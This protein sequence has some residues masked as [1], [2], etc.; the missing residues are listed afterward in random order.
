MSTVVRSSSLSVRS[1]RCKHPRQRRGL[2]RAKGIKD[3]PSPELPVN[4][5]LGQID[6]PP[7]PVLKGSI[8]QFL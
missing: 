3:L 7:N 4:I 1:C 6:F 2:S 5:E 8:N